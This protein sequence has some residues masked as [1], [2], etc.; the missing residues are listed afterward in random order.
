MAKPAGRFD[1][2]RLPRL[3]CFS[4]DRKSC[5]IVWKNRE[6]FFHC[7]EKTAN[8]FHGVEHARFANGLSVNAG[9]LPPLD[10]DLAWPVAP[11]LLNYL[12]DS[13]SDFSR[14]GFRR[15]GTR[16]WEQRGTGRWLPSA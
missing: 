2:D 5:S 7:V 3:T 8:Y 4:Q 13:F 11:Q 15:T 1:K 10:N 6:I 16:P 12:T 9:K 14:E